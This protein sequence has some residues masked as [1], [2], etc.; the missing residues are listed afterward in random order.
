MT[1]SG[2]P[3]R[4]YAP[5]IARREAILAAADELF[6]A[7]GYSAVTIRE[8]AEASQ[9]THT[10]VL[11]YFG[12]KE[13]LF[14]EVITARAGNIAEIVESSDGRGIVETI[15]AA[16]RRNAA[17]PDRIADQTVAIAEALR[18]EHPGYGHYRDGH[19]RGRRS[20]GSSI[21][22]Q[23]SAGTPT[24]ALSGEDIAAVIMA[25]SDGLQMQWLLDPDEV[26][27]VRIMDIMVR[28][29]VL[30]AADDEDPTT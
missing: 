16:T 27:F 21:S 23:R 3:S 30:G 19:R 12:S 14:Q 13:R 11:R 5:G 10:S 25:L 22:L 28:V 4:R 29:L 7:R 9:T 26:D 24:D 15:M 18:P 6:A 8:I 2:A 1:A 17:N 20:L